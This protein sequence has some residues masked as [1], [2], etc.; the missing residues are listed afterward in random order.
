MVW[1]INSRLPDYILK[2]RLRVQCYI[3]HASLNPR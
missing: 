2:Q 1:V 3:L